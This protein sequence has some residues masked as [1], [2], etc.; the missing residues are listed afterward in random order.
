MLSISILKYCL[1]NRKKDSILLGIMPVLPIYKTDSVEL[2]TRKTISQLLKGLPQSLHP[3]ALRYRRE[4]DAYNF[5]AGRLLLKRGLEDLGVEET[6]EDIQIGDSGKP[7]LRSV[8]FNISHTDGLV[9]CA[10]SEDGR[11][12]IDVEKERTVELENFCSWFTPIEWKDIQEAT[13]PLQQFYRYWTRKES[14]IKAL[15]LKLSFLNQMNLDVNLDM[16]EAEGKPWYLKELVL[17]EGYWGAI[18]TEV[19]VDASI[20]VKDIDL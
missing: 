10:L 20:C 6:M 7:F 11:I 16:F 3:R 14:M 19:G 9:V 17:G 4:T 1:Q 5:I 13:F 2:S 18:C 15:G 12:G 8:F